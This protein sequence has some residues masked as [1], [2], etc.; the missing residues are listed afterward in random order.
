MVYRQM[1]GLLLKLNV[2]NLHMK[3]LNEVK[4]YP[5]IIMANYSIYSQLLA[6]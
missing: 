2:E 3:K 1:A 5:I 4:K 6:W